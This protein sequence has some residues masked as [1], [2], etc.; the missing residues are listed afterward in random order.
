MDPLKAVADLFGIMDGVFESFRYG[1]I[2]WRGHDVEDWQLVPSVHRA[3]ERGPYEHGITTR[4]KARA[5]SRYPGCPEA[6]DLAGWLFLMQHYGL[7]TRLLDWSES[8]LTGL[9]FAVRDRQYDGDNGA[10]WALDPT[11]MNEIFLGLKG[12]LD[13]RDRPVGPLFDIHASLDECDHR[14]VAAL[15]P[16]QSDLRAMV[17]LSSFTI[18]AKGQPL[19]S[20]EEHASYLIKIRVDGSS[21]RTIRTRLAK[22]GITDSSLFPDL[23]HLAEDEKR[24]CFCL[25]KPCPHS[26]GDRHL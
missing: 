14:N 6:N 16:R 24:R 4:F 18:H 11:R 12:T 8:P 20:L 3:T 22:L 9:H 2:W 26:S 13:P 21:K 5:P 17:Q 10:L 23:E 19:E 7:P 1:P 15:T 25:K